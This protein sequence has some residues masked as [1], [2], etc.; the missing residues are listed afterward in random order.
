[1]KALLL[2]TMVSVLTITN[3]RCATLD[4]AGAGKIMSKSGCVTCH[5][6][7]NT[8]IGPAYKDVA[9]RYAKL[10]PE[11]L[12]YLNGEKPLDYLM[13]KVRTGTKIKLNKNW[14]K[15]PTGKPYGMMTP[16]PVSKISDENLKDLLTYILSLK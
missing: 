16:N 2:A 5:H 9:Q 4:A 7:E 1:M 11:T 6:I 13:K 15:A 3:A 14:I 10:S 8:K 12:A